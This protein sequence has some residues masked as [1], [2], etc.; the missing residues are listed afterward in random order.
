MSDTTLRPQTILQRLQFTLGI[1]NSLLNR[2]SPSAVVAASD[3]SGGLRI[4]LIAFLHQLLQFLRDHT[5]I[6]S[7]QRLEASPSPPSLSEKQVR[8]LLEPILACG[9][10]RQRS[11]AIALG[12]RSSAARSQKRP[13][14][15]GR[16]RAGPFAVLLVGYS[17]QR[18][19]ALLAPP[20]WPGGAPAKML[21]LPFRRPLLEELA[22]APGPNQNE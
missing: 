17:P 6:L 11:I 7:S 9:K 13:S 5:S 21:R 12:R 19:C 18:E 3:R 4:Q 8:N 20:I 22:V 10:A 1:M 14:P 2:P 16:G 15:P